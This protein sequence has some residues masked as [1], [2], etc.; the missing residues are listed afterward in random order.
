MR[1][2]PDGIA[3]PAAFYSVCSVSQVRKFFAKASFFSSIGRKSSTIF[4]TPCWCGGRFPPEIRPVWCPAPYSEA[5]PI[6]A[7]TYLDGKFFVWLCQKLLKSVRIPAS[8]FLARQKFFSP[9]CIPSPIGTASNIKECTSACS[10]PQRTLWRLLKN[11]VHGTR[12]ES[13]WR[14]GGSESFHKFALAID[15]H[16]EY[17]VSTIYLETAVL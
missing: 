17:N 1:A 5:V 13:R 4:S 3:H 12:N 15:R 9:I 14:S 8:F 16:I 2:P 6:G 11:M 7:G 10:A